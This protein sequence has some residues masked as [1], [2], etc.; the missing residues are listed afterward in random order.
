MK[1]RE[2]VAV[3]I[4]DLTMG[5]AY[6]VR[7]QSMTTTDTMDTEASVAQSIRMIDAGRETHRSK[8]QGSKKLKGN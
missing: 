6:P 3:K 8:H 1:R 5:S 4:G 2:T 7:V